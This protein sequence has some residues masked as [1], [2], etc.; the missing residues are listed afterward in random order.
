MFKIISAIT[1]ILIITLFA[2]IMDIKT[3]DKLGNHNDSSLHTVIIMHKIKNMTSFSTSMILSLAESNGL[4]IIV[5]IAEANW[6][7]VKLMHLI[8]TLRLL[9]MTND[10]AVMALLTI[11]INIYNLEIEL[12]LVPSYSSSKYLLPSMLFF[13]NFK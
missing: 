10:N 6:I 9:N 4:T 8:Q 5:K 11:K 1:M 13:L 7:D 3:W 2:S 12:L